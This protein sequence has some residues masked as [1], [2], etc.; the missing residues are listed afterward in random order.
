[1]QHKFIVLDADNIKEELPEY[2][3]WN[4]N[5]LHEE[6]S[7]ILDQMIDFCKTNG[8]NEVID[9]TMKTPKSAYE[10]LALF[11]DKEYRTEAHYMRLPPQ[12][13]AKRAIKR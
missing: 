11:K 5:Q 7:D 3:G 1:M 8:L 13:A 2:E 4:A 12:E 6:S 9:M 10:R